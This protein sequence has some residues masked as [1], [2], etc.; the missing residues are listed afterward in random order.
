MSR[1]TKKALFHA[2]TYAPSEK[3]DK[4]RASRATRRVNAIKLRSEDLEVYFPRTS[5]EINGAGE[6]MFAKDGRFY[7]KDLNIKLLRK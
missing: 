3:K 1:S 2:H 6:W 4:Q 5:F 7:D